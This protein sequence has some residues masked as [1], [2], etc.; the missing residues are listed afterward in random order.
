MKSDLR[1]FMRSGHLPTTDIIPIWNPISAR[2]AEMRG[3]VRIDVGDVGT[4]TQLGGF[5][6]AFN[7]LLDE[8]TND[9]C[10]YAT[11][12]D[13]TPFRVVPRFDC[14]RAQ[15]RMIKDDGKVINL[16]ACGAINTRRTFSSG[17]PPLCNGFDIS[18]DKSS[19]K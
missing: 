2:G 3:R 11:P 10:G 18:F 19:P 16:D 15:T 9:L 17:S 4:F 5:Q 13:F 7:I 12:P 14:E 6:V 1:R 8:K